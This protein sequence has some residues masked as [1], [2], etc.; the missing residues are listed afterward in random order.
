MF[1]ADDGAA[2]V[3]QRGFGGVRGL[4]IAGVGDF[5]FTFCDKFSFSTLRQRLAT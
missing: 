5:T 4:A 3:Q 1:G 2:L